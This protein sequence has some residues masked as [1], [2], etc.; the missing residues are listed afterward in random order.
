MKNVPTTGDIAGLMAAGSK[1]DKVI[2]KLLDP[3][4]ATGELDEDGIPVQKPNAD[5]IAQKTADPN[6]PVPS[7]LLKE[8][9][10]PAASPTEIVNSTANAVNLNQEAVESL[11]TTDLAIANIAAQTSKRISFVDKM[12]A[13]FGSIWE[14]LKGKVTGIFSRDTF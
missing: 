12:F 9:G 14:S 8:L 6:A 11:P 2:P 10:S 5:V 13:K 7:E 1:E 4:S 3:T